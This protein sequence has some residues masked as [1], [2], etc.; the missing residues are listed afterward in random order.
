[1]SVRAT[2][3]HLPRRG[4]DE[5]SPSIGDWQRAVGWLVEQ[6][7][8]QTKAGV[9]LGRNEQAVRRWTKFDLPECPS[10]NEAMASVD[11]LNRLDAQLSRGFLE[12]WIGNRARLADVENPTKSQLFERINRDLQR[13]QNA[14]A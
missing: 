6:M 7:G 5:S 12:A 9:A 10:A 3:S 4:V 13:L 2:P 14:P 1:M 11:A 8:S